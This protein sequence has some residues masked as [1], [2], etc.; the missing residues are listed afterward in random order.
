M[1]LSLWQTPRFAI[2]W[3]KEAITADLLKHSD[4]NSS[5]AFAHTQISVPPPPQQS[6]VCMKSSVF[7]TVLGVSFCEIFPS[8][9]Q[10][11][12]NVTL[13]KCHT[14]ISHQ[15]SRHPWQRTTEKMFTPHYCRVVVPTVGKDHFGGDVT[16]GA[17]PR[18][19]MLLLSPCSPGRIM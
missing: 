9:T 13:R 19:K 3:S 10:T 2:S 5:L 4:L 7:R 15:I 6:E 1:G 18:T 16:S 17:L 14:K 11:L 12:E 8:D